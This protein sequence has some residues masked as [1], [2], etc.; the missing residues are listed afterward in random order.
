MRATLREVAM[1]TQTLT[2]E[3]VTLVP[4][5]ASNVSLLVEWT[6]GSVSVISAIFIHSNR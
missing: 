4:A 1:A 5:D 3:L 2:G 6:L